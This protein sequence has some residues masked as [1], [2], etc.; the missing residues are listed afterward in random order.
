MKL[1]IILIFIIAFNI[2]GKDL[3]YN[4][5][6][7]HIQKGYKKITYN[8]KNPK[9]TIIDI[10]NLLKPYLKAKYETKPD[11]V[12]LVNRTTFDIAYSSYF[13]SRIKG[14]END[15]V[16]RY[17]VFRIELNFIEDLNTVFDFEKFQKTVIY[18]DIISNLKE[19]NVTK[20]QADTILSEIDKLDFTPL[21]FYYKP[22]SIKQQLEAD[23][24]KPKDID[25]KEL[26]EFYKKHAQVLKKAEKKY[27]VNKE[28]IVGI[29]KKETD[30]GRV[31][32]KYNLFEVLL[33]QSSYHINNPVDSLHQ[34]QKQTKRVVRLKKSARR[35]LVHAIKHCVDSNIEP[36]SIKSNFV[37]AIGH[38]Q[39]MPFNL[40]L[41]RD[42]DNNKVID[43]SDIDDAIMS[44]ANFLNKNG[45]RKTYKLKEIDRKKVVKHILRYNISTTY[46]NAVFDMALKLKRKIKK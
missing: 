9:E 22:N 16:I 45:Y 10:Y 31:E 37:G 4:Q 39:F 2:F 8:D 30:L 18:K 13:N 24:V 32:L 11:S 20:K 19:K 42:G 25:V 21:H 43:L 46:A 1:Y 36:D 29:L 40:Y 44:I 34:R 17:L 6:V 26:Y 3:T 15:E 38:P 5:A 33:A 14:I 12:N 28:V 41:A 27:K 7:E 35:S 23:K